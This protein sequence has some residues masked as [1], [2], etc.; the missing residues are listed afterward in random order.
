MFTSR[1]D[2]IQRQQA[3]ATNADAVVTLNG[4]GRGPWVHISRIIFSY[5]SAPTNGRLTVASGDEPP[6]AW[7]VTAGGIGPLGVHMRLMEPVTVTLAAGGSGVEG[8]VYVEY[9]KD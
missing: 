1:A 7:S 4:L 2:K 5:S 6:Y 8:R 9:V 3:A